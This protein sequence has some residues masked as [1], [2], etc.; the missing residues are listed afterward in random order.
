MHSILKSI[1]KDTKT[2]IEEQ[3]RQLPER[4][5]KRILDAQEYAHREFFS[6]LRGIAEYP[7]KPRIIAEIKKAS[8]SRGLISKTFDPVTIAKGYEQGGAAAISVLTEPKSFLGSLS[9]LAM[10]KQVTPLPVLRKD[11]ILD[12]YQIYDSK[13][14]HADAILL[15][16]AILS[17]S[18]LQEFIQ[19]STE[20]ELEVLVEVHTLEELQVALDAHARLIGI[21]NRNLNSFHVTLETTA[22]LMKFMPKNTLTVCESGIHSRQDVLYIMEKGVHCFLIGESLMRSSNPAELL[23]TFIE[24]ESFHDL[25]T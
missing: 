22:E 18:Q 8:P 12:A 5:L 16:A 20:L 4:D 2:L 11:F 25:E 23:K 3:K 19:L 17:P 15:I 1:V 21:N 9:Y 7:Q 24:G 6:T 10:V 14:Y 13:R